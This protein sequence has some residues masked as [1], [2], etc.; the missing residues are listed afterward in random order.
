MTDTR[1]IPRPERYLEYVL[2]RRGTA[3][4]RVPPVCIVTH[5]RRLLRLAVEHC[6]RESMD[7]GTCTALE[8]HLL[9][10][11]G[12]P[13]FAMVATSAGAPMAAVVLEEL[14]ALGSER[15]L[16]V[17]AAGHP[18]ARGPKQLDI[19]DLLVVDRALVYEGTSRHYDAHAEVSGPDEAATELLSRSLT[20]RGLAHARGTVATTDAIYRE[21]P[22]FIDDIVERGALGIDMELSA[23]FTVSRFHGKRMAG[24][25]WMSD[26]VSIEDGWRIGFVDPSIVELEAKIVPVIIDWVAGA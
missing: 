7:L 2:S 20:R 17:G 22:A 25:V 6:G 14:V 12:S 18:V 1:S 15:F 11:A 10:R 26:I 16:F 3:V 4:P 24:V 19:G 13:E 5:S 9:G 8:V 21:T 23:L